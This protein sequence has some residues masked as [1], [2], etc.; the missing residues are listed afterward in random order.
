MYFLY[1]LPKKKKIKTKAP[2]E[3]KKTPEK[4]NKTLTEELL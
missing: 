3:K 2:K 4:P 1:N